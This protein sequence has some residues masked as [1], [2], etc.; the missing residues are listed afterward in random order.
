MKYLILFMTVIVNNV[1][2]ADWSYIH[3]FK[4]GA[5][6]YSTETYL[7]DDGTIRTFLKIVKGKASGSPFAILINCENR[8]VRDYVAGQF[9]SEFYIPWEPIPPD[10]VGEVAVNS[11]CKNILKRKKELVQEKAKKEIEEEVENQIQSEIDQKNNITPPSSTFVGRLKNR[12]KPNITFSDTQLQSVKGNPATQ[13]DVI[14]SPSGQIVAMKLKQSSGNDAWDKAV[15]DA[16]EKTGQL[17]RDENGRIPNKI[18]F[19]FRPRD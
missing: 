7:L 18:S 19:E 11:F 15:F 17:P 8:W 12:I 16:I 13:V 10:S 9:G 3:T 1:F 5:K 2:A 4:N 14:C 6:V